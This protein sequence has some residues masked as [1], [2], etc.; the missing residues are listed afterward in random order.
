MN[1]EYNTRSHG[2]DDADGW[3]NKSE[4][5]IVT[6]LSTTW[7]QRSLPTWVMQQWPNHAVN[8]VR[9]LQRDNSKT[10][11]DYVWL[12]SP[13]LPSYGKIVL[14]WIVMSV[15]GLMINKVVRGVTKSSRSV[16]DDAFHGVMVSGALQAKAMCSLLSR[17]SRL[18]KWRRQQEILYYTLYQQSVRLLE[19]DGDWWIDLISFQCLW[20][21][22]F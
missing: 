17:D 22:S 13:L 11:Q 6:G 20:H 1:V 8:A 18:R 2:G 4:A 12:S 3:L 7:S 15:W 5:G 10:T 9:P 21:S 16:R 14:L 19:N